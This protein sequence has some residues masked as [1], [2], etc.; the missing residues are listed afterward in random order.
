MHHVL[1]AVRVGLV[2]SHM[3]YFITGMHL[4]LIFAILWCVEEVVELLE[5]A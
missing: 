3:L 1:T 2:A 4:A 5:K